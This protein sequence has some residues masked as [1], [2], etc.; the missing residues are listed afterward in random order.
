MTQ[1]YIKNLAKAEKVAGI[2]ILKLLLIIAVKGLAGYL[3]GMAILYTSALKSFTTALSIFAAYIGIKAS[4]RSADKHFEYGYYKIETFAAFIASILILYVGERIL[5]GN[6]EHILH[7][8]DYNYGLFG[9]IVVLVAIGFSWNF[10]KHLEKAA[11]EANLASLAVSAKYKKI[12]FLAS[13]AIVIGA[14][15]VLLGIPYVEPILSSLIALVIVVIS[16][17]TFKNSLF[18]LLDY[19]WDTDLLKKVKAILLSDGHIVKKV[20]GVKLRQ[21]GPLIF[22]EAI[23]EINPFANLKDVRNTINNIKNRIIELSPYIQDFS[24]FSKIL[25]PENIILAV[26]IKKNQGLKSPLAHSCQ[27][28][29]EILLVQIKGKRT[30]LKGVLTYQNFINHQDL[31]RALVENKVNVFMAGEIDSLMYYSLERVN[32]IQVYPSFY[33][34][35]TVEEAAKMFT[36]DN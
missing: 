33:N 31:V 3:T 10:S 17:K 30:K 18:C 11:K 29:K 7:P 36:I 5:L 14:I 20:E 16:I 4:Q 12:D 9:V 35:K 6:I 19:W 1:L 21:A 34:A 22:G 32:Q 26:P 13:V 23:L 8:D 15:T 25:C 28:I 2:S 27:H 24:I